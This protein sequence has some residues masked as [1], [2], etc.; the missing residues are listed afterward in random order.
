MESSPQSAPAYRKQFSIEV[1]DISP[2]V[3][4]SGSWPKLSRFSSCKNSWIRGP[5]V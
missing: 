3:T 2:T 1:E 5:S 4:I